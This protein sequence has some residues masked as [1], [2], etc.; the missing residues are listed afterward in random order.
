MTL[1]D[2]RLVWRFPMPDSQLI[3]DAY[4]DLERSSIG[5]QTEQELLGDHNELPKPWDVA[6]CEDVDLRRDVWVWYD[7]VVT[8]FNHEYVWDP[9][10]GMIPPC[11]PLHPHLVHE[12]GVLADQRRRIE[13]AP[14][15]NALEEWHRYVV[16]TL[17]ERT[18]KR[19]KQHCDDHHQAWPARARFAHHQ[20]SAQVQIRLEAFK[21]DLEAQPVSEDSV[22]RPGLMIVDEN[23]SVIDPKTGEA[24]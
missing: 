4:W 20:A 11:W 5:T 8:W 22:E 2:E 3:D 1:T 23:G 16:P 13:M 9:A 12:I 10:A 15:G 6:T 14:T 7:R 21:S 17:L 24:S 19:V 18:Q